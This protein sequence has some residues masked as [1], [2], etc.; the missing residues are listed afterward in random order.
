MKFS[1]AF[2]FKDPIP[3][4]FTSGVLY[5]LGYVMNIIMKNTLDTF[6]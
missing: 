4:L 3:K 6:L 5:K 1:N 2:R